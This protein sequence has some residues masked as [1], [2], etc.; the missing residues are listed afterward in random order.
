MNFIALVMI[1]QIDDYYSQ[2][3]NQTKLKEL[4]TPDH[5]PE[6]KW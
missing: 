5:L 2:C 6:I 3:F 1:S 4:L